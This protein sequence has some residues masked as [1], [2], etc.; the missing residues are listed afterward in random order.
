MSQKNK[1]NVLE[2]LKTLVANAKLTDDSTNLQENILALLSCNEE[3]QIDVYGDSRLLLSP[4][5][6]KESAEKILCEY[7]EIKKS[8][9]NEYFQ[10]ELRNIVLDC[11][12]N[13]TIPTKE[14]IDRLM[15]EIE[16]VMPIQTWEVFRPFYGAEL[17]SSE[18]FELGGYKIYSIPKYQEAVKE[19]PHLDLLTRS[20]PD[21]AQHHLIISVKVD[22][23]DAVKADE[24]ACSKFH[25]FDNIIRYMLGSLDNS[26]DVGVFEYVGASIEKVFL[27]SSPKNHHS[28][29]RINGVF[30]PVELDGKFPIRFEGMDQE[31][32]SSMPEYYFKNAQFGHEWIWEV[33]ST[34][35]PTKLQSKIITAIEWVGKAIRDNDNAR[36]FVQVVFAFESIFTF[37][38]KNVLVSPGIANQISE[39]VAFILGTNLEER[40]VCE[41]QA[42]TIYGNRSA[43]AHGGSSSISDIELDEAID[44]IKRVILKM[45]TETNFKSMNSIEEFYKW[46]QQQKYSCV[47]ATQTNL[48]A[49]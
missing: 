24:L 49:D 8:I 47:E 37:Q 3:K 31:Q 45:T 11:I 22:A 23:R 19:I 14:T 38:E 34:P 17:I 46:M 1:T 20:N 39:S 35:N 40:I 15:K 28:R 5:I 13:G 21:T 44:L 27:L 33:A 7:K 18:T 6:L 32:F 29:S 30:Q 48:R 43:I 2:V 26:L 10:N 41:K 16:S 42:K 9:S 25:Q 36:A 12:K 4:D